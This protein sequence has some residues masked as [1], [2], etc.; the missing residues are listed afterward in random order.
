MLALTALN[1]IFWTAACGPKPLIVPADV[2]D[3]RSGRGVQKV[4]LRAG[5]GPGAF[6]GPLS[7]VSGRG[8]RLC[9]RWTAVGQCGHYPKTTFTTVKDT[10]E[11]MRLR[12][13][14]E[15]QSQVRY[16]KDFEESKGRGFSM[17]SDTPEMQ[18]LRR[19]QEHIKTLVSEEITDGL[20]MMERKGETPSGEPPHR[21]VHSAA[22]SFSVP[23]AQR[24]RAVSV[25]WIPSDSRLTQQT[26][27][28]RP[29]ASGV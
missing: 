5:T 26:P 19:T 20:P 25:P 10:P 15:L 27:P 14:S 9:W 21:R 6:G 13:Q 8:P 23:P 1:V 7:I 18:R 24:H 12:Q 4:A 11:N 28:V 17:V 3:P 22:Q 16:K 2:T 29:G